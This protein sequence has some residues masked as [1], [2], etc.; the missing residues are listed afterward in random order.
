VAT[1][2]IGTPD[3][4]DEVRESMPSKDDGS[5]ITPQAGQV[6]GMHQRR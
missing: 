3:S 4:F 5:V 6:R 2:P 1:A